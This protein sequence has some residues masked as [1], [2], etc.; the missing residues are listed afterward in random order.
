MRN[1]L[2]VESSSNLRVMVATA[3]GRFRLSGPRK[4]HGPLEFLF[5]KDDGAPSRGRNSLCKARG[6][7]SREFLIRPDTVIYTVSKKYLFAHR[8]D[9]ESA[10][11]RAE[12][13]ALSMNS[14]NSFQVDNASVLSQIDPLLPFVRHILASALN[15]KLSTT[16]MT[17]IVSHWGIGANSGLKT[18]Q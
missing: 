14:S 18:A 2:E 12:L 16:R 17:P 5:S 3:S 6:Y 7:W 13:E 8:F 11:E 1:D 15:R 4:P 10:G 9:P